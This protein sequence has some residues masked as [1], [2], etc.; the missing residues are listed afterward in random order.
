MESSCSLR[1]SRYITHLLAVTDRII[2]EIDSPAGDT[3]AA[4]LHAELITIYLEKEIAVRQDPTEWEMREQM[5]NLWR[6]VDANLQQ[7]WNVPL[8]A[9]VIHVST[10]HL[11]RLT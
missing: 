3:R 1:F 9:R 10:G 8:M 5:R 4:Q 11:H 7:N 6:Q 2:N